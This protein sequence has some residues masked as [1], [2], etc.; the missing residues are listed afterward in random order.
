MSRVL[1]REAINTL[2]VHDR[3]QLIADLCES[4]DGVELPLT[5]AHVKELDR[6]EATFEQDRQKAI[7]WEEL[8]ERIETRRG[9]A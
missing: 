2:S 6:R 9:P 7:T 4:L 8:R 3:L 1:S 5:D